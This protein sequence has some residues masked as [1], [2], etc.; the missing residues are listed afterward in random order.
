MGH[1]GRTR[2]PSP[3]HN[4]RS[5]SEIGKTWVHCCTVAAV[6]RMFP[7][8]CQ[9]AEFGHRPVSFRVADSCFRFF[10]EQKKLKNT[11]H[12]G[13]DF[14]HFFFKF[15]GSREQVQSEFCFGKSC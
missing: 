13:K 7:S 9:L 12:T 11:C 14:V 3:F 4:T 8:L 5:P 15:L 10:F 2:G 1:L 6:R